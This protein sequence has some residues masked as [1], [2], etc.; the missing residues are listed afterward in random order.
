MNDPEEDDPI[1]W[2][3]Y[4][5]FEAD[6]LSRRLLERSRHRDESRI[7]ARAEE[8][9]RQQQQEERQARANQTGNQDGAGGRPLFV[10]PPGY[11][12]H[13]EQPQR[14]STREHSPAGRRKPLAMPDMFNGKT[15]WIDYKAHFEACATLNGW[16]QQEK[17]DFLKTRLAGPARRTLTTISNSGIQSYN[18][19]VTALSERF[20]PAGREEVYLA[21]LRARRL[22]QDEKPQDLGDDIRR[23][24]EL[25]Y[26]T[27]DTDALERVAKHH[28]LDAITDSQLRHDI[29]LSGARTLT[30]AV[31]V[32]SERQ[33]FLQSEA[34]RTGT[35]KIHAVGSSNNWAAEKKEMEKKI[36]AMSNELKK[37][38]AAAQGKP[39]NTPVKKKGPCFYCE[40]PGHHA[41]ECWAKQRDMQQQSWNDQ[42]GTAQQSWRGRGRGRGQSNRGFRGHGR[43]RGRGGG[44][45][46]HQVQQQYQDTANQD[47]AS[48]NTAAQD[49]D[50]Q[51]LNLIRLG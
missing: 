36:D 15:S 46:H 50:G 7:R 40:K 20:E 5:P 34:A 48:N 1:E 21:E 9:E 51:Q 32:A 2:Q 29:S 22:K 16:T 25:A 14:M 12:F 23:M 31:Q 4:D 39:N 18:D 41:A 49:Q 47:Q 44:R 27:Y 28:F 35:A 26:P 3:P 11:I 45:N 37:W 33:A 13:P 6:Q 17:V 38:K 42:S 8:L 19:I 30:A 24:C 43:G 10:L